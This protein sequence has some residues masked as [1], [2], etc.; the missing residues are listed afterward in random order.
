M[1]RPRLATEA[2]Y[3]RLP[4]PPP[5][6]IQ[7]GSFALCPVVNLPVNPAQLNGLADLYKMALEQSVAAAR[8][9]H[10]ANMLFG[11]WN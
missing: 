11:L 10:P 6:T 5:V 7:P 8:D 2:D 4:A 9:T 1:P 3:Y